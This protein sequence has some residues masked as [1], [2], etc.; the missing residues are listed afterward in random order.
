MKSF[1][2]RASF[3]YILFDK[4]EAGVVLKGAEAKA[5]CDGRADISRCF[6]KI[7]GGELYLVNAN[8]PSAMTGLDP[9]RTRKLLVHKSELVSLES[10]M[11]QKKLT[12]VPLA[13]Y[14]KGRLVKVE[15]AL[16]RR[17]REFEKR[18][19]IKRKDIKRDIERELK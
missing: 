7:I 8:I 4:F 1:N 16:A 2:K 9:T 19:S 17:K 5:V 3:E 15:L 12:I 6:A 14:T 11:R 18:E 10:K 13:I